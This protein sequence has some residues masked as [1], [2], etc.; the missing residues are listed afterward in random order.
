MSRYSVPLPDNY[1]RPRFLPVG[2]IF[3]GDVLAQYRFQ[4]QFQP[5]PQC[6]GSKCKFRGRL[7]T[8]G[9]RAV[10]PDLGF[11]LLT[12]ELTGRIQMSSGTHTFTA[13]ADDGELFVYI[14]DD[15]LQCTA[16]LAFLKQQLW[17]S[18]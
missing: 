15:Q 13:G 14:I 12:G 9:Y 4:K 16:R 11:I 17:C 6:I 2:I 18:Y 7:D 8:N 3:G 5:Q 1:L 10:L